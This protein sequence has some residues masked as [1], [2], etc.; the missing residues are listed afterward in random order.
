MGTSIGVYSQGVGED[1]KRS[2]YAG[3]INSELVAL[4]GVNHQLSKNIKIQA[5]NQYAENVFNTGLFQ[6]DATFLL[7]QKTSLLTGFQYIRQDAIND[8][9]N[10]DQT[11]TYL[12]RNWKSNIFGGKVGLKINQTETSLSYT[13]ITKDGR[14]IMPRE[15]GRE[16]LFTFIPRERNEGAGDVHA[17]VY[18]ISNHFTHQRLRPENSAGY[19]RMPDVRNF[20][21]NKYGMP[22]YWQINVALKHEF[23]GFMEGLDAEIIALYKG[24]VGETYETPAFEFNKV[25]MFH[26]N[27]IL[28]YH[29]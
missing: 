14:F 28:N 29:F 3:N 24:R 21:L 8:G 10:R 17:W 13:R 15:W 25:D 12:T 22:S 18:R 2:D 1:G 20:R 6:A 19:Y 26:L 16:P 23:E 7:G 5:W 27:V 4:L 9:G 11:K